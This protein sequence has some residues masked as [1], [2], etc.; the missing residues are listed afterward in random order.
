MPVETSRLYDYPNYVCYTALK[1][2]VIENLSIKYRF[3]YDF[4]KIPTFTL[5]NLKLIEAETRVAF[6]KATMQIE[7]L[8]TNYSSPIIKISCLT[9]GA[10]SCSVEIV[11]ESIELDENINIFDLIFNFENNFARNARYLLSKIP[12]TSHL[13]FLPKFYFD[14]VIVYDET[15]LGGPQEANKRAFKYIFSKMHQLLDQYLQE[16]YPK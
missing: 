15:T 11:A 6:M 7:G 14:D 2:H 1:D 9:T 8:V 4:A 13:K 16:K 12:G 10:N 5:I 3:G